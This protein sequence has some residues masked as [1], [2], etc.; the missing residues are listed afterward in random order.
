[1]GAMRGTALSAVIA[2]LLWWWQLHAA[3][4]ESESEPVLRDDLRA[5]LLAMAQ[6]RWPASTGR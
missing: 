6:M 3:L 1:M 2:A 4:R 5:E